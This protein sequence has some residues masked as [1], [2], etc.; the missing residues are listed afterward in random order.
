MSDSDEDYMSD[1]LLQGSA[2]V[3]DIRP[4]LLRSKAQERKHRLY[5]QDLERRAKRPKSAKE[6]EE[7]RRTEGLNNPIPADNKGF[8]MLAKMGYR[9]GTGLGKSSEGIKEPI[10]IALKS[11]KGGVGTGTKEPPKPAQVLSEEERKQRDDVLIAEF[12]AQKV[13]N[14]STKFLQ[15]DFHK[16]QRMIQELDMRD[17]KKAPYK[18]FYWTKEALK[19][20]EKEKLSEDDEA[21]EDEEEDDEEYCTDSNL[22][23]MID[24]C[25]ERYYYCM[26][27]CFT[28]TD[29]FDLKENCPGA[30]RDSHDLD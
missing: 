9:A 3:N 10:G 27:C 14:Q 13:K 1:K 20:M 7:S 29:C 6:L 12:Q 16:A 22:R 24:Y 19:M 28:G 25:R 2:E 8:Q 5:K 4:G 18:H 21:L 23:E 17:R 30:Y 26:Y 11:N 15:K